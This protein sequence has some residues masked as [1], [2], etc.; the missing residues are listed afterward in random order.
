RFSLQREPID[1]RPLITEIVSIHG[2]VA[3]DRCI[4]LVGDVHPEVARVLA[5]RNRLG[6]ALSNLVDNALKFTPAGGEVRVRARE[7]QGKLLLTISDT[8]AG[9]PPE[10]VPHLF[11]RFWRADGE[12]RRGVGLGLAIAKGI[13]DAHGGNLEVESRVG[14][15]TTFTL[16]L[17]VQA[18]ASD[19]VASRK[20]PTVL[21][22]DDD[23][24][25]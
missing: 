5:D 6:Q 22:V 18:E 3:E 25:L 24:T 1:L 21:V 19:S 15:G 16:A 13:A 2:P 12:S 11:D 20:N 17:T 8:G 7:S 4:A 23:D 9:I 14:E 10:Q